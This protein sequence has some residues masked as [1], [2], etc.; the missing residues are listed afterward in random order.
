MILKNILKIK[1]LVLFAI[2][3]FL[4]GCFLKYP[5]QNHFRKDRNYLH[6]LLNSSD[7]IV[8]IPKG[9]YYIDSTIYVPS[10]KKINARSATF[11]MI[12]KSETGTLLIFKDIKNTSWEGGVFDCLN[13]SGDNGIGV[14]MSKNI[15]IKN[16]SIKNCKQAPFPL[17]GGRGITFHPGSINCLAKNIYIENCS[18]GLDAQSTD[19]RDN[20][21]IVYENC[22]VVN[23]GR[24]INIKCNISKKPG[25]RIY[26]SSIFR[27][28][29]LLDCGFE[30]GVINS[31]RGTGV[32]FQ[33]ISVINSKKS[34]TSLFRGVP[35]LFNIDSLVWE[36]N[37]TN[38]IFDFS[39]GGEQ[40]PAIT[41]EG[42]GFIGVNILIKLKEQ[43]NSLFFIKADTKNRIK[44]VNL[45]LK[46]IYPKD[47]ADVNVVNQT[48]KEK[49]NVIIDNNKVKI[50]IK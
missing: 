8:T 39:W 35:Y 1:L 20:T 22:K 36:T 17:L 43:N 33:N 16:V 26:S 34:A 49:T 38:D 2:L 41:P 47:L 46:V 13:I 5:K 31:D 6:Y 28:I 40:I 23:C 12:S 18:V 45:D 30:K 24:G 19:G 25:M 48:L 10:N 21:E 32:T 37:K 29:T 4:Q 44:N 11:K 3:I 42:F 14:T 9:D 50:R 27:N 15:I 7:S